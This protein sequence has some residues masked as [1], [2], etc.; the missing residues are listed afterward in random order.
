VSDRLSSAGKHG[1]PVVLYP[2]VTVT[3]EGITYKT[4]KQPRRNRVYKGKA[5]DKPDERRRL[6]LFQRNVCACRGP[7]FVPCPSC[8][9]ASGVTWWL[10]GL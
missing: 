2:L 5:S 10:S 9:Q 6:L 3:T 1:F 4:L 8:E 7:C